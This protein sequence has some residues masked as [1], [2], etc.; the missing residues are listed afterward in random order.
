MATVRSIRLTAE[1]KAR[2][3]EELRHLLS[4][5]LPDIDRRLQEANEHGDVSDNAE[6][7]DLKEERV[8]VDDRIRELEQVL[9]RAEVITEPQE[10][11]VID[12]GSR[13]TL[14]GPDG[15][16]E[17]WQIVSPEEANALD[18]SISTDS[19]VGKALIGKRV[20]DT[21]TVSTPAGEIVFTIV[22]VA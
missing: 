6:Y 15:E 11:G 20:G 16:E 18:G 8:R 21:P 4:V 13:V 1:G 7:E 19:P 9:A 5:R 14:R 12:L 10:G 2:L 22:N 3:E 17:T